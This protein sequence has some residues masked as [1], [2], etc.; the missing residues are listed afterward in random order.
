MNSTSQWS[1]FLLLI[2]II[3]LHVFL[4]SK[5]YCNWNH[6][7]SFVDSSNIYQGLNILEETKSDFQTIKLVEDSKSNSI[8]LFL[9][10]VLQNHSDEYQQSHYAMV[11]MSMK[12]RPKKLTDS[13]NM[14]VLILGG[15]DGYTA[16]SVLNYRNT[17][18]KN[19][20]IDETLVD[21]IK[22]NPITKRLTNNAFENKRLNMVIDD[23]YSYIYQDSETYDLIIHDIEMNTN[24]TFLKT[25][26]YNHDFFIADN[27]LDEYGILN[28]SDFDGSSLFQ[29]IVDYYKELEKD[30]TKKMIIMFNTTEHFD[31]LQDDFL[32]DSIEF[33]EKYPEAEI[34][35]YIQE[36]DGIA[37]G[38]NN[39]G[40]KVY[41]YVAK[42]PMNR[43][44]PEF[45]FYDANL[46]EL[47]FDEEEIIDEEDMVEEE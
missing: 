28:Y 9:N 1:C 18:V 40:P 23:A 41:L 4:Q 34:G 11:D 14:K 12:L 37:C 26:I 33:K 45:L 22:T 32:F 16:K 13:E 43:D 30:N 46:D 7:E 39:F 3:M 25:E 6:I 44:V 5:W 36:Y 29:N 31:Y 21:L 20:E 10:D 24:E 8:C 42:R 17:S 35:I 19:V 15:G 38:N 47:Y 27:L 2:I